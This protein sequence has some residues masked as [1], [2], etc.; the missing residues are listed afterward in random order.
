MIFSK[1]NR[2]QRENVVGELVVTEREFCRD[3]KLTFEA[4]NKMA[5][6]Q[7]LTV[8]VKTRQNGSRDGITTAVLLQANCTTKSGTMTR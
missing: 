8:A 7:T 1:K 5:K 2:E 3:L 6:W 4:S